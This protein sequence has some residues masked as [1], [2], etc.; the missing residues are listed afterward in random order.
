MSTVC[1]LNGHLILREHKTGVH[2]FHEIVTKKLCSE[3][4]NYEIKVA[5]FDRKKR[6][7]MELRKEHNRWLEPFVSIEKRWPRIFSYI[8]PI[9]LFFGKNDVYFCDGLIPHTFYKSKKIAIVHDLMVKIYPENYSIIKRLYLEIFFSQLKKADRI[10]CVSETTKKDI[11]HFYGVDSKKIVVCYNGVDEKAMKLTDFSIKN[12][13][14]DIKKRY[15]LYLGDMRKNKNLVNTVKGFI[16]FCESNEVGDLFFYIAG[17]LNG[18][19]KLINEA[20]KNSDYKEN[21]QFLGY[22][23]DH[24]KDVLYEKCEAVVLLSVYEGFGMPIIEGM[25]HKKPIITSNCSSMREVGE[26]IALLTDPYSIEDI[27]DKIKYVY[28]GK[29]EVDDK[30]IQDKLNKYSFSNVTSIINGVIRSV[31]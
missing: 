31:I 12:K 5:F 1:L 9:E 22:V 27:A 4:R 20:I 23:S 29:F 13:M 24:D 3:D 10:V 8:F 18:D 14:I 7:A 16:N 30:K 25:Q 11:I 28:L 2:Y 26:G 19:Y 21:V 17:S 6:Y 15:L